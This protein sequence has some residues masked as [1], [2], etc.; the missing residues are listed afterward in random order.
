MVSNNFNSVRIESGDR[1]YIVIEVSD[2]YKGNFEYFENLIKSFDNEFYN[3][4]FTFFMKRDLS[5]FNLRKLP[6]TE[7]KEEL[8]E[9]NKSSYELFVEE[10]EEEFKLGWICKGCY[11]EYVRFAKENGFCVCASNTFG[12]KLRDFVERKKKKI[13][14]K[15]EWV[16]IIKQ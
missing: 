1:R 10:H 7:E 14:G 3:N 5:K 12:A 11:L 2:K 15:A 8:L 4:L 9:V 16:Y 13:D 6:I